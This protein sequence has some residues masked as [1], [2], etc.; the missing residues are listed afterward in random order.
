MQDKK[1]SKK[2][3]ICIACGGSAGHIFPGLALAEELKKRHSEN[4]EI[5][6]LTTA[7]ELAHSLFR[8]SGFNFCTLPVKGLKKGSMRENMDF[9]LKLFSGSLKSMG[10]IFSKR[11]SCFVGFGSYVSG[12]PFMAA[13]LLG[14]PTLI[15]EQNAVMGRAN[16]LMRRFATKVAL[17]FPIEEESLKN[18]IFTGNPIRDSV[19]TIHD[20]G[21]SIDSLGLE[22]NK[23]TVLIIGGSQGAKTINSVT[24]EMLKTMETDMLN[25]IQ[26]IHIA[27]R[28]DYERLKKDYEKLD[29]SYK[30]YPFSNDMATLYSASDVSI[31]RAGASTICELLAHRIPSI[32]IPYPFAGSHQKK[33]ALFLEEKKAAIIIEE[34][35]LSGI[36]LL[37]Q[38]ETLM[39]DKKLKELIQK[40]MSDLASTGASKKLADEVGSLLCL[41]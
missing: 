22:R 23:F 30:L 24:F 11:P 4:I 21:K 31:S 41:R 25:K 3:L 5:L 32:L 9:T 26:L 34:D 8:G 35:E 1:D 38:I 37:K 28:G 10:I 14:L 19:T 18:V 29:I 13:W 33:N 27:G 17:S 16:R 12:P 15:H 20:K 40:K 39:K 2:K 6:F 36:S 7:N